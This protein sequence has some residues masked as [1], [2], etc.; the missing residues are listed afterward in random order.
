MA[1]FDVKKYQT[2]KPSEIDM[3]ATKNNFE[4]FMS[5]YGSARE[6]VGKNRMP[7]ITQSFS[8]IPSSTNKQYS[9]DAEKFLIEREEFMPEYEQLHD[10]FTLGYL[11]IANPLKQDGTE[12]R[13]QIFMLRYV[14]GIG[15]NDISDRTY[16]GKTSIVEESQLG[17]IQF[18]KATELIIYTKETEPLVETN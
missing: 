4:I 5:A 6:K 8:S 10:I 13:R 2:P 3:K 11:S 18:C 9:G 7:K 14:Y 12:R 15:V 17:F 16:L 1:L